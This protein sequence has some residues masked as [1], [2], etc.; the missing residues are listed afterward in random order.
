MVS[1]AQTLA[2]TSIMLSQIMPGMGK[3]FDR[4]IASG[5]FLT[6]PPATPHQNSTLGWEPFSSP[7]T[8]NP[9]NAITLDDF[10]S[11]FNLEEFCLKTD[12]LGWVPSECAA[13]LASNPAM[14]SVIFGAEYL[15]WKPAHWNQIEKA[16]AKVQRRMKGN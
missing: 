6:Q 12:G 10:I 15:G 3:N 5:M 14:H 7:F 16:T 1:M 13:A 9:I 11:E 4:S 2:L 8:P